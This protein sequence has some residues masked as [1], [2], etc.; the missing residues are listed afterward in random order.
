MPDS[1]VLGKCET[2]TLHKPSLDI[3]YSTVQQ[4]QQQQQKQQK[5]QQQQQQ[6]AAATTFYIA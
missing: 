1:E 4:Q 5:Q 6:P 2:Q 3:Q